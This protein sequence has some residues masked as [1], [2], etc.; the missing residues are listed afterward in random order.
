MPDTPKQIRA[1]R[2]GLF[3]VDLRAQEL[4]KSGLK[5]RIQIFPF[6]LGPNRARH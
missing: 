6:R 3:E 5:V 1:Y 4:H 2:F